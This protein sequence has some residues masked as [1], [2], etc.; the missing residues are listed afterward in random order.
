MTLTTPNGECDPEDDLD[1]AGD[2][3]S[4]RLVVLGHG[5]GRDGGRGAEVEHPVGEGVDEDA[6]P[7]S[8]GD[9]PDPVVRRSGDREASDLERNEGHREAADDAAGDVREREHEGG[10]EERDELAVSCANGGEKDAAD[11]E[12]LSD[13]DEER[14]ESDDRDHSE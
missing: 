10:D 3:V 2:P 1:V 5:G 8:S 13:A 11:R 6:D 14:S 9:A 4:G 12:F 7:Q